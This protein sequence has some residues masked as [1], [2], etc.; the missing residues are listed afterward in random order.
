MSNCAGNCVTG[1]DLIEGSG[2]DVVYANPQCPTHG[3]KLNP[4]LEPYDPTCQRYAKDMEDYD[5]SIAEEVEVEE[6][7][8]AATPQQRVAYV[9][10]NEGTYNPVNGHFACDMCYIKLGMPVSPGGWK[11]P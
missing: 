8:F 1:N 9:K 11:M 6:E 3:T 4:E 10:Y 2:N 5:W 7:D